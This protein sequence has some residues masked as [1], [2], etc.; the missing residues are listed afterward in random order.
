MKPSTI[1]FCFFMLLAITACNEA[2]TEETPPAK[3]DSPA[4]ASSTPAA[5]PELDSATKMKNWQAYATPSDPHK[6]LAQMNGTWDAE[7][8]FW[9]KEG[10]PPM[11]SKAKAVNKMI[12]NGLYQVSTYTGNVMGA[13]FEGISTTG[14]DNHTKV[15]VASWIDN[16]GSGLTKMEGTYNEADKTLTLTGKMMDAGLAREYDN[17][18][19]LKIIDDKNHVM[20]MYGPKPGGGG[21]YKMMEIKYTKAN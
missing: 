16:L 2:A 15:F 12:F 11:V 19:V 4:A 13:P 8:S 21:E 7:M 9:E 17:R 6:L 3:T 1:A 18:Q 10:A 20:E 14:Y 5:M